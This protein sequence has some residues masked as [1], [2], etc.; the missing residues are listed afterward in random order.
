MKVA[1]LYVGAEAEC[2]AYFIRRLCLFIYIPYT[3]EQGKTGIKRAYYFNP[4]FMNSW[5]LDFL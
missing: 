2:P 4:F 1:L 3:L 5:V